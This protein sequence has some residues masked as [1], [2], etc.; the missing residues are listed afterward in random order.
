MA[1]HHKAHLVPFALL[2]AFA[3]P[4]ECWI[5]HAKVVISR[6]VIVSKVFGKVDGNA[7]GTHHGKRQDKRNQLSTSVKAGT[8]KIVVLDKPIRP[9]QQVSH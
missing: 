7:T 1:Y 8:H 9:V 3:R 4:R 5:L 2:T 6:V